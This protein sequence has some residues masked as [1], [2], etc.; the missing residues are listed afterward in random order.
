MGNNHPVCIMS[1]G[2][3]VAAILLAGLRDQGLFEYDDKVAKHWPE[4]A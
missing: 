1:S 3:A 2:K 4:F